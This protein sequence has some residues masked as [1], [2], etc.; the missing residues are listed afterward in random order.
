[1]V[2]KSYTNYVHVIDA[3]YR[4]DIHTTY[5]IYTTYIPSL[6]KTY[7]NDRPPIYT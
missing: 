3:S 2:F 7:A 4:H 6:F 1:M 5:N